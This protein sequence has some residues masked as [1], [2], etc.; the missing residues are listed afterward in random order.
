MD[1]NSE[2]YG[3][4]NTHLLLNQL[5]HDAGY[6]SMV[7]RFMKAMDQLPIPGEL[8][9]PVHAL[10]LAYKL[11]N[12][13]VNEE[14]MP[15]L[16]RFSDSQSAENAAE[17]LDAIADSIYVLLWTGLRLNLPVHEAFLAVQRANMAK[18][19]PEG[20]PI[21][22]PETGKVM[23]PEGWKPPDILALVI[24]HREKLRGVEYKGG[25]RN[26]A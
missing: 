10:D 25:F 8:H 11:V 4:G 1:R 3:F 7:G 18:L 2:N 24:E 21:K 22:N 26:G 23:K 13:E 9:T 16:R 14:F 17:L 15:A 19:G 5:L 6:A 20:K 12:E